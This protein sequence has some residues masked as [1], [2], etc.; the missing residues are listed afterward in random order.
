MLK[1]SDL[2]IGYKH[3][4]SKT[5]YLQ[6]SICLDALDAELIAIVGENGIGKSTFLRTI[7][8]LQQALSGDILINEKAINNLSRNE[9]AKKISYVSTDIISFAKIDVFTLISQGRFP[10][11]NWFGKLNIVDTEIVNNAIDLLNLKKHKYKYINE[12]SD[13]ER[14]RALIARALVQDTDIIILDEPTAFL[15][16][17]NKYQ[18]TSI[19]KEL[20]R[21]KNKT[22]IF[23]SHDFNIVLKEADKIWLFNND[24]IIAGAP[25]D[26][27]LNNSFDLL[28]NNSNL[29]FS[30]DKGD[31]ISKTKAINEISISGVG[32]YKILTERALERLSYKVV[33]NDDANLK[34]KVNK[35]DNSPFWTLYFGDNKT[36]TFTS[37]YLLSRFLRNNSKFS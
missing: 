11:T 28:F 7:A 24:S 21:K 8:N 37:I 15:D 16:L 5:K 20:T 17:S 3:S 23:S 6:K 31:F 10:Y 19:L 30:I 9:I 34:L 2:A 4:K 35:K 1:I 13:G 27:V 29:K 14:Q 33:K 25:E 18:I 36:K 22:I 12:I 32:D 26:L